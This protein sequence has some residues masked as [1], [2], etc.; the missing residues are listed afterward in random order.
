[1]LFR[2]KG[3]APNGAHPWNEYFSQQFVKNL[4]QKKC[5]ILEECC[6]EQKL[7]RQMALIHGMNISHSNL[8]KSLFLSFESEN[9]SQFF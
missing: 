8:L 7:K 6:S 1:M 2:A 3:K 4:S 9:K 5:V